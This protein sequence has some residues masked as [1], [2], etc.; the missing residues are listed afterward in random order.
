MCFSKVPKTFQARKLFFLIQPPTNGVK[1]FS[2]QASPAHI[3]NARFLCLAFK[4]NKNRIF[5]GEHF[6]HNKTFR[7]RKVSGIFEKRTPGVRSSK[8]LRKLFRPESDFEIQSLSIRGDVFGSKTSA[9][10]LLDLRFFGSA[11]KTNEN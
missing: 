1:I 7:V 10:F 8:H 4:I 9:K 5:V 2:L 11:F 6:A 3:V